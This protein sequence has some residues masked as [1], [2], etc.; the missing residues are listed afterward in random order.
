MSP[1]ILLADD[2]LAV[3]LAMAGVLESA[4][5]TVDEAADGQQ[6]LEQFE[7][8]ATAH[9]VVVADINMPRLDGMALIDRLKALDPEVPVIFVTAYS[10]VDSAIL[11][12]RKG[13]F[14]YVTKPFRNEQLVQTVRNAVRL[15][16]LFAENRTLRRALDRTYDFPEIVGRSPRL[17]AVLRVV[18][19]A[20]PTAASILIR[21]ETG[22]G[23]DL[24]ARAIHRASPRRDAPF[25][26]INCAAL[27]EGLLESELFGHVKGAFTGAACAST[28]LLR[29]AH[30]GTLLLDELGDMPVAMQAK[31]LDVLENRT[32]RPVG[33][34]RSH[35]VDVRL[36]AATHRD[37]LGEVQAGRFRE[38]LYY[39][40]AVIEVEIPPL[41]D[42]PDDI[43]LLARHFLQRIARDRRAPEPK[44]APATLAHMVQYPWP[45]NVRELAHALEHAAT[46]GDETLT[47]DDLPLRMTR[48]VDQARDHASVNESRPLTLA[49]IERRHVLQ[50]MATVGGDRRRAASLLGIDLSTLYRKLKRWDEGAP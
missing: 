29:A 4:G 42:R 37:L 14:D 1:P 22:T 43:P 13:A 18:E 30:G 15:R 17:S 10:S 21:G 25:V 47:V 6:A 27:P 35:P 49:E 38:D 32:V 2:D 8:A 44:L 5:F 50:I 33:S 11:A 16:A 26:A 19:R 23:K 7:S 41:R 12:L 20:A 45:G 46:L 24:V 28:G 40:C 34:T 31:L 36:L 3:R 39:R 9:A 48:I